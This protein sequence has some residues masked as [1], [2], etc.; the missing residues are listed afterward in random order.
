MSLKIILP[1][2]LRLPEVVKK[3]GYV[4]NLDGAL[5]NVRPK[6]S[7]GKLQLEH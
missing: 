6:P 5:L 4:Y 2:L 7:L 1:L 3:T